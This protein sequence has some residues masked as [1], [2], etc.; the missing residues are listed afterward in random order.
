MLNKIF[1]P[2]KSTTI[3]IANIIHTI[4]N[5]SFNTKFPVRKKSTFSKSQLLTQNSVFYKKF[6]VFTK[7]PRSKKVDL[8]KKSTFDTKFRFLTQNT[9][10]KHKHLFFPKAFL[11]YLLFFT[12]LTSKTCQ[13]NV[14]FQCST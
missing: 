7:I 3:A 9:V 11:I 4:W 10:H 14:L 2:T 8:F 6:R 5:S 13:K 12:H 1:N